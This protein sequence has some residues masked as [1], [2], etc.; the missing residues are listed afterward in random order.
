MVAVFRNDRE[1]EEH[2]TRN[3]EIART[4]LQFISTF[5]GS[6]FTGLFRSHHIGMHSH[7]PKFQTSHRLMFLTAV[8]WLG[9]IEMVAE[10]GFPFS[11][12]IS[13]ILFKFY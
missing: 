12:H 8:N 10:E 4:R 7:A 1:T 9:R 6:G 3:G 13:L 11:S 2:S 5:A